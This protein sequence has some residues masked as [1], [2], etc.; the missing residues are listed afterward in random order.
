MNA[1]LRFVRGNTQSKRIAAGGVA[2]LLIVL[3]LVGCRK[4][5]TAPPPVPFPGQT[6]QTTT[7]PSGQPG[8]PQPPQPAQDNT[9]VASV[10]DEPIYLRDY[11]KQVAEW[12][13]AFVA[14]NPDLNSEEKQQMLIQ[15]RRQVLD[16]MIEQKLIEQAA[17]YEGISLSDAEVESVIARD[18]EENGGKAQF[19]AWLQ[20]NDWTYDE[21]KSRQRSMMLSSQMFERVTDSVPTTAE[22][23]NARHIL[24]AT[25]AEARDILGQLQ[26]GADFTELARQH[27]LDPSTKESGG[28]LGFFPRG[29]LVVPQV[30]DVA[31]S[32]TKDQISDVIQSPMGYH[33]VQVLER[34]EDRPLTEESWQALKEATFRRWV[35]ELWDAANVQVHIPL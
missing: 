5:E 25:E 18:I 10:S 4:Q 17:A 31:F 35:S 1:G 22:Q 7:Q 24:V 29:T 13:T 15:G 21:Y 30:E 23:V 33:I 16:V 14:Q 9:V 8:Q 26:G 20:A 2:F 19:E 12:E 28:D 34:V 6:P 3:A 27:S 32:I 11:Q